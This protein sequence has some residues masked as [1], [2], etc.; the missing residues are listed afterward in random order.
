MPARSSARG[1]AMVG[2]SPVSAGSTPTA[3]H[4]RTDASGSS[5]F[6]AA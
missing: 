1:M 2:A 5:P 4:D 6:A 3:A